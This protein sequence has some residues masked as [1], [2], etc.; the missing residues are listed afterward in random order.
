MIGAR[1][2]CCD[3][4]RRA[5]VA[6]AEG[7]TGI[8]YVEVAVGRTVADPTEIR[9]R[10]VSPLPLP[11]PALTGQ[12]FAITG[13][14]RFPAPVVAPAVETLKNQQSVLGYRLTLPG[15]QP[16]DFS[17]YSLS[18]VRGAGARRPPDGFDPRLSSVEIS[19]KRDCPT[20]FDCAPEDGT[21]PQ[22]FANEA[23]IIDRTARD[24]PA[25][26][27]QLLD[28]MAELVPGFTGAESADFTTTLVEALA[29]RLDQQSYRLD[30]IGTEALPTTARE[31]RSLVR[32]ARLVDY[33]PPQGGSARVPV[34]A[35][36]GAGGPEGAVMPA[37][38]PVLVRQGDAPP[39]LGIGGYAARLQGEVP[40]VFETL[41]DLPLWSWRNAIGFH[42]W[43]DDT[44]LLPRG[45]TQA[46]LVDTGGGAG[47]IRA[48]DLLVLVETV[49]PDTGLAADADPQRRH[50]VR[51]TRAEPEEDLLA[52]S[53]RLV[54][55]TWGAADALPFDLVLSARPD[56]ANAARGEVAC[57]AVLGNVTLADHGA[58]L[59]PPEHL[60]GVAQGEDVPVEATSSATADSLRPVLT[61]P[62]PEPGFVWRPKLDRADLSRIAPVDLTAPPDTAPAAALMTV[63]PEA[64]LPALDL[65]DDFSIW[66]ARRDLVSAGAFE[67]GFV[68]ETTI[69]G[70]AAL[71]F[72]DGVNGLEPAP[73]STI[74]A[75]ARIGVGTRGNIG[76]GALAHCVLPVPLESAAITITNPLAASGGAD[77]AD[78]A[79]IRASA[80]EAFRVQDRA[81]TPED[82]AEVAMRHPEV[83]NATAIARW[84]GAWQTM[85]IYVDRAEGRQVDPG[86]RREVE[87]F[88]DRYRMI[89][90]DVAVRAPRPAPLDI[91]L[92]ICVAP[93]AL[94]SEVAAA[95]R[96]ALR[97]TGPA[98]GS[99]GFFHPDRLTFGTPLYLSV[100]V[101]TVMAVKDVASV[102]PRRF[103]RLGRRDAGEL[104]AGVIRPA[105]AEILEL[106][107]D[108]NFPERGRL[109][110]NMGG[111]R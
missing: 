28:R 36:L 73:G 2:T 67:R 39:V 15:G 84:T 111:G 25:L 11:G 79:T 55:V 16:T 85:L 49:A 93:S 47:P 6:A 83:V 3:S 44:C 66:R 103:Q 56:G 46:T 58:S 108:P 23:L 48:G 53:L 5:A 42:T 69:D 9:V 17:T 38:T 31:P 86:F 105:E 32:H 21:P 90:C 106:A 63:T 27:R 4:G 100:L 91:H 70:R 65:H 43:S 50:M 80:P 29:Y 109:T 22:S 78:A 14:V 107:D 12:N 59:P 74:R 77:P 64:A 62:E 104:R 41:A 71:R 34:A 10:L 1:Y 33:V 30:W 45:A 8:D 20:D 72:G 98:D 88:L 13:G 60:T 57:A 54:T 99:P 95:V 81:I 51:V 82:Y 52:P 76:P 26:R 7:L 35:T 19:F 87:D 40:V 96:T 97:P 75:T 24:W 92:E 37:R 89:G 18:I 61:P 101:A 68:V 94:R 110:L 102:T